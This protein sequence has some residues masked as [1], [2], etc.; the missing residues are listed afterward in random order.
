M[1]KQPKTE[2]VIYECP[3][4]HHKLTFKREPKNRV[5]KCVCAICGKELE[6]VVK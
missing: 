5:E 4:C 1:I 2:Y 3:H 6:V